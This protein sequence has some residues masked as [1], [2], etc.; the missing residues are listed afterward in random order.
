MSR[1]FPG[2]EDGLKPQMRFMTD[3]AVII[4]AWKKAHE[5]IRN[6]NWYSNTIEL[7]ISCV[8]LDDLYDPFPVIR[9]GTRVRIPKEPFLKAMRGQ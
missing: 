6:R 5:Y 9:M 7:D 4:Q 1:I 3:R 2:Y 8:R